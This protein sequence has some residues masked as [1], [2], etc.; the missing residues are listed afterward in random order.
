MDEI[1][2]DERKQDSGFGVVRPY[3]WFGSYVWFGT[4]QMTQAVSCE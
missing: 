4:P 1:S 2:Q 3:V